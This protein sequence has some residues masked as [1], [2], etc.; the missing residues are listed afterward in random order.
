MWSG[1]AV[2]WY[3][4]TMT[5]LYWFVALIRRWMVP[6]APEWAEGSVVLT[7]AMASPAGHLQTVPLTALPQ[8]AAVPAC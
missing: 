6:L 2:C 8:L 3:C 7:T 1:F 4:Q 5:V